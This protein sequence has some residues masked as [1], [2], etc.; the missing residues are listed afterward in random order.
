[1]LWHKDFPNDKGKELQNRNVL[2]LLFILTTSERIRSRNIEGPPRGRQRGNFG[3]ENL[4]SRLQF[5]QFVL[6][7]HC[8]SGRSRLCVAIFATQFQKRRFTHRACYA[9]RH[10]QAE[11]RQPG[12]PSA[13]AQVSGGEG[14]GRT[15]ARRN[16]IRLVVV[17]LRRGLSVRS[18][19]ILY[20]FFII[21]AS[22][23]FFVFS[24]RIFFL[25][26]HADTA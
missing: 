19:Y 6:Q 13:H 10:L 15:A 5:M 7:P 26:L 17:A 1:M 8:F 4:T 2:Q 21:I 20:C 16:S 25:I 24:C 22:F 23:S 11:C 9:A 14:A 12:E 3:A 18:F